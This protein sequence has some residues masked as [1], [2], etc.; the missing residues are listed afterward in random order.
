VTFAGLGCTLVAGLLLQSLAV[1]RQRKNFTGLLVKLGTLGAL[2]VALFAVRANAVPYL[3][4]FFAAA[5]A[6]LAAAT[7]ARRALL[8]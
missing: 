5:F 7:L 8:R 1:S 2:L 4:A 6:A 3:V